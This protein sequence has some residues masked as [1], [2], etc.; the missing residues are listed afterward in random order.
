MIRIYIPRRSDSLL[1]TTEDTII[2]QFIASNLSRFQQ[3]DHP[4]QSDF[5]ALFQQYSFKQLGYINELTR[6]PLFMTFHSKVLVVNY[7]CTVGHGFLPGCYVSLRSYAYDSNFA[8]PIAYPKQ[9]NSALLKYADS[10]TKPEHLYGFTGT[11]HSHKIRQTVFDHLS[12]SPL[13]LMNNKTQA[14]HSHTEQDHNS[15]A[16]DLLDCKFA[17]C[18]RGT[19]PSTYRLFEAMSLGRVPVIISDDWVEISS[20]NWK[21]FSIRIPEKD[22]ALIETILLGYEKNWAVM[23]ECAKAEWQNNFTENAKH[24]YLLDELLRLHDIQKENPYSLVRSL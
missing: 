18:P 13:G 24:R 1:V 3:V 6:D 10:Q 19:S 4:E 21:E 17:L 20:V 11:L 22:T 23:A 16:K 15:Y 5:I 8:R 12:D 2:D 9:Y 7:D 14:F